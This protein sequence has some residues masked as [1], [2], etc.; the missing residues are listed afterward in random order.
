MNGYRMPHMPRIN[1]SRMHHRVRIHSKVLL[2]ICLAIAVVLLIIFIL[3]CVAPKSV[4]LTQETKPW[5]M[6][7]TIIAAVMLAVITGFVI[8]KTF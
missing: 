6:A 1:M 2:Y 8:K 5:G 7:I 4:G 3:I